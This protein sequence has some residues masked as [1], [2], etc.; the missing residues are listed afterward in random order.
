MQ[1]LNLPIIKKPLKSKNKILS[2]DDYLQF[3]QFNLMNTFN[4]KEY[5][6]QKKINA[7]NYPFTL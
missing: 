2:M 4:K 5:L 7:V 1:D 6:K 3:V